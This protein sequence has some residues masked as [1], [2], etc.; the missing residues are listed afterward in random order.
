M[1]LLIINEMKYIICIFI[2]KIN[3]D[4]IEYIYIMDVYMYIIYAIIK[5][6]PSGHLYRVTYQNHLEILNLNLKYNI[7]SQIVTKIEK[8]QL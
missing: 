6:I 5:N 7:I 4:Y 2:I 8:L 3:D 1:I